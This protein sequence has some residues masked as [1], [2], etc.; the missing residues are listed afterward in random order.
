MIDTD[1]LVQATLG[2]AF[3]RLNQFEMSREGALVAYLRKIL[4]NEIRDAIRRSGRRPTQLA[5]DDPIDQAPSPLEETVAR[6]TFECYERALSNLPEI[7]REAIILRLEFGYS[8][9]EIADAM[10]ARSANTARMSVVRGIK[11]VT[12]AMRDR[13][14]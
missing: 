3:Q 6:T 10:G 2:R 8:F 14:R 1:D 12:E 9:Q 5:D 13:G 4:L 7:Q 11:R